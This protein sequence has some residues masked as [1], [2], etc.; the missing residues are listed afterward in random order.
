MSI[1]VRIVE[2]KQLKKKGKK[3]LPT[4]LCQDGEP[5]HTSDRNEWGHDEHTSQLFDRERERESALGA[6]G[7]G[8]ASESDSCSPDSLAGAGEY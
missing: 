8:S 6:A 5:W 1:Y 3:T 2:P 7:A 4:R